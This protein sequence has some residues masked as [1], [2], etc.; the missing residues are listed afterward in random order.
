MNLRK[1][2]TQKHTKIFSDDLNISSNPQ[3]YLIKKLLNQSNSRRLNTDT[4]DNENLGNFKINIQNI[5]AND[6]KKKKA[7]KYV[8]KLRRDRNKSPFLQKEDYYTLNKD[9]Q[10]NNNKSQINMTGYNNTLDYNF[11]DLYNRKTLNRNKIK[12]NERND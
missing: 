5:F 7:I 9:L 8:I 3:S 10:M 6:D 12:N 4:I 2:D 1:V 11:D